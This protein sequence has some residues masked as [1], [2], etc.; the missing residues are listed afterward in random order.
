M[1]AAVLVCAL[2]I[3]VG[4][5]TLSYRHPRGYDMQRPD[6]DLGDASTVSS[7]WTCIPEVIQRNRITRYVPLRGGS[8]ITFADALNYLRDDEAF[9]TFLCNLL[10]ASPWTAYRW[11][12][13]PV[14]SASISRQFEFVLVVDPGLV[15]P[16]TAEVFGEH[17]KRAPPQAS[18][19]TFDS[20]GKDAVLIV[21]CPLVAAD[22]YVHLASFV[23]HAP[24][25]QIQELWKR[26]ALEMPSRLGSKPVWLSTAGM[27]VAWLHVRIDQRPKYYSYNTYRV[28]QGGPHSADASSYGRQ[29]ERVY[30]K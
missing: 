15:R 23:R 20:L 12:T 27:G 14:S 19:V 10:V 29:Q 13:P 8:T 7:A 25:G 24:K 3:F 22:T 28:D 30:R 21:P 1:R 6:V 26:V 2:V 4:A 9:R 17:F 18:V 5:V 16:P 11:E